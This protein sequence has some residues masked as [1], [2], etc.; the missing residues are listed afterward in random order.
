MNEFILT[1][2]RGLYYSQGRRPTA[3]YY[4]GDYYLC[5]EFVDFLLGE[6]PD[7]ITV[8]IYNENTQNEDLWDCFNDGSSVSCRGKK[9][10]IDSVQAS[11]LKELAIVNKFW[12]KINKT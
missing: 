2:F 10:T 5:A 8:R 9:F 4:V 11:L 6:A 1:L 7:K 12:I 3:F